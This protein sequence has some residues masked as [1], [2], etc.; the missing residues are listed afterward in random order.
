MYSEEKIQPK[1]FRYHKEIRSDLKTGDIVLFSGDKGIAPFIKL[2]TRSKWSHVG[3]VYLRDGDVCLW[4][5]T[6]IGKVVDSEK[7]KKINGVQLPLLSERIR[8][9][10]GEVA[11]R[12]ISEGF[13]QDMLKKLFNFRQR[14]KGRKYEKRK[15]DLLLSV[16]DGIFIPEGFVP[17]ASNDLS[18]FFCSELIAETYREVGLLLSPQPSSEYTPADFAENGK[19]NLYG[20]QV[21]KERMVTWDEPEKTIASITT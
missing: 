11:I 16:Y 15:L 8:R 17:D 6:K 19:V 12:S 10:S 1:S 13:D 4:E 3:M 21:G 9:F 14:V 2:F 7:G 5:A 18:S 20:R